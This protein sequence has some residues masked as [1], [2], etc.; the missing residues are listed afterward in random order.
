MLLVVILIL[1]GSTG[2]FAY[3]YFQPNS[4][5]ES[6]SNQ[7]NT[8]P[9]PEIKSDEV[10]SMPELTSYKNEKYGFELSFSPPFKPAEYDTMTG[11]PYSESVFYENI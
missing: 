10:D 4:E 11:T 6:T 8:T 7:I 2:F 5:I 3:H 1:L 9:T